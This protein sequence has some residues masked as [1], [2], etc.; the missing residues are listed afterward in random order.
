[1][2]Y[3][4]WETSGLKLFIGMCAQIPLLPEETVNNIDML[5]DL[6]KASHI[7]NKEVCMATMLH[8]YS[9]IGTKNTTYN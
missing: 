1:M 4:R 6:Q 9:L 5:M 3:W 2:I 7:D 8:L